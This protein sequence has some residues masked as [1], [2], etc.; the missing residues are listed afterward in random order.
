[1]AHPYSRTRVASSRA[2][3][4]RRAR[5]LDKSRT[6]LLP[7][8]SDWL[9]KGGTGRILTIAQHSSAGADAT[10]RTKSRQGRQNASSV[11][12]GTLPRHTVPSAEALGYFQKF[13][14]AAHRF[15]CP[16]FANKP[17]QSWLPPSFAGRDANRA[18]SPE[19]AGTTRLPVRLSPPLPAGFPAGQTNINNFLAFCRAFR[20]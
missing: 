7:C 20:F 11:P 3:P 6:A 13:P 5:G 8:L 10:R 14:F 15:L 12:A 4:L 17:G 1:M 9:P 19:A 2:I 16:R 18:R